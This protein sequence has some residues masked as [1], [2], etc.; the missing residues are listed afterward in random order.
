MITIRNAK[1]EDGL[2]FA[3]LVL[4]SAAYFTFLFGGNIEAVLQNFF[5]HRSNLFSYKNTCI[6]ELNGQVA[7][8]VLGYDWQTK[9]RENL[10]TGFLMVKN[11]GIRI[12]CMFVLLIKFN[13]TAGKIFPGDYYISNIAIYPKY[14]RTGLGKKLLLETESRA[15][16]AGAK[17]IILDVQKYNYD[18]LSF[19]KNLG[20]RQIDEFAV[21]LQKVKALYLMRMAKE[22]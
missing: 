3:K 18:A 8:M 2:D 20:Y 7:G 9:K 22:I 1:P 6:L 10:R 21:S 11:F 5:S 15:K 12:F 16:E 4:I 19:Y 13:R 14:R 17:R